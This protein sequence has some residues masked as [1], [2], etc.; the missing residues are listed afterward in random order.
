MSKKIFLINPPTPENRKIIRNTTC[1][2]ESKGNYLLHSYDFILLSGIFNLENVEV[3]YIDCLADQISESNVL[4][5]I[6]TQSP[7]IIITAVVDRLWEQD[8]AFLKKLSLISTQKEIKLFVFGDAFL[9]KKNIAPAISLVDGII[10]SPLTLRTQLILESNKHQIKDNPEDFGLNLAPPT[11]VKKAMPISIPVPMHEKFSKRKYRF[12]FAK[13]KRYA[14]VNTTWGCPYSCSYCPASNLSVFYREAEEVFREIQYIK[15]LGINEIYFA[16]FSFGVPYSNIKKLLSL[17]IDNNLKIS[18]STYF[19][20]NQ[21]SE[22]LLTLMKK[23]GC[24]TI[25]IGVES[26]NMKSLEKY[27]RTTNNSQI[28]SLV[29]FANRLKIDVCADF[30]LGLPEET[31]ADVNN[32]IHLAKELNI[33][34]ASFN[35]ATPLPG[36][37]FRTQNDLDVHHVDS[38]GLGDVT[39]LSTISEQELINLKNKAV[40]NF[41]MRPTYLLKRIMRTRS[42]E[43][44]VI[45]IEEMLQLFFKAS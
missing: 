19:H 16:D 10:F 3:D 22:E 33:D 21:F 18:W 6:Q 9:E 12:P 32:T 34:F 29:N 27:K 30:I 14:T 25:I 11:P 40:R 37:I 23:S 36:S 4:N 20:P 8:L 26:A 2:S 15:N 24:H 17:I 35:I 39:S 28:Q 44:F 7:D 41:Y 5:F 38:S 45:Q 31:I 1:A 13:H 43:H 42:L